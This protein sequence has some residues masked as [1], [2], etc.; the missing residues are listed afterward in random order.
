MFS[1][2]QALLRYETGAWPV[3]VEQQLLVK[4]TALNDSSL[5]YSQIH[6]SGSNLCHSQHLSSQ[7]ASF[8]RLSFEVDLNKTQRST[9]SFIKLYDVSSIICLYFCFCLN[10][11]L[12]V[13]SQSESRMNNNDHDLRGSI[14]QSCA[15]TYVYIKTLSAA[16]LQSTHSLRCSQLAKICFL[17]FK[18]TSC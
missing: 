9:L 15:C 11:S 6:F 17:F 3:H 2:T 8:L 5:D 14:I 10:Q 7:R 4:R 1:S 12:I 13:H 18:R 16:F